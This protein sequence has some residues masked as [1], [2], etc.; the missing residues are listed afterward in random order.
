MQRP[1][2][3]LACGR[4]VAPH[5]AVRARVGLAGLVTGRTRRLAV[6]LAQVRIVGVLTFGIEH[7]HLGDAVLHGV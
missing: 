7:G 3:F 1:L 4:A 2:F 6:R 5:E